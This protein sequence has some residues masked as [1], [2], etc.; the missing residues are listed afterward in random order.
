MLIIMVWLL[1]LCWSGWAAFCKAEFISV[2]VLNYD[3]KATTQLRLSTC[4]EVTLGWPFHCLSFKPFIWL[5]LQSLWIVSEMTPNICETSSKL[6]PA[7]NWLTATAHWIF[8][9]FIK[10][11]NINHLRKSIW[12]PLQCILGHC[13]YPLLPLALAPF[14]QR[15]FPTF[16][17]LE[18]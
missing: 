12:I 8:V 3:C 14:K 13:Y 4:L 10:S 2:A 15:H 16:H 5:K 7:L 18:Q 9:N 6:L 17:Q 11:S 1:T